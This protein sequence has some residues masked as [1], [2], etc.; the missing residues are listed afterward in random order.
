MQATGEL[1]AC[2]EYLSQ[3]VDRFCAEYG[4]SSSLAVW[5]LEALEH[6]TKPGDREQM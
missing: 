1:D 6:I 3:L 5:A 2:H 4:R